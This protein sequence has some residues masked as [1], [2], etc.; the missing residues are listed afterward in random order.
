MR[1]GLQPRRQNTRAARRTASGWLHACRGQAAPPQAVEQSGRGE[2]GSR[3]Q[4]RP[5]CPPSGGLHRSGAESAARS[6]E[7]H[8]RQVPARG[9]ATE[10]PGW[11][12]RRRGHGRPSPRSPPRE[13]S[14][15][16]ARRAR[17]AA[18]EPFG[19]HGPLGTTRIL[20][21]CPGAWRASL[22]DEPRLQRALLHVQAGASLALP[23]LPRSD[24]S[25]RRAR[26]AP[27]RRRPPWSEAAEANHC[28]LPWSQRLH[29]R[30][31][32]R[33]RPVTMGDSPVVQ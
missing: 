5:T 28:R 12:P 15:S 22:G 29:P 1:A 13:W 32:D 33:Q 30:A 19:G 6:I 31:G 4:A 25:W 14:E 26:L 10:G 8:C 16:S 18:E 20:P 11:R 21:G 27:K 23:D 17:R 7:R 2:P 24:G 3:Q 9:R